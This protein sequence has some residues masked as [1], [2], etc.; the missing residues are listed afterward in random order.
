MNAILFDPS[1][2]DDAR[3]EQLYKGQLFVYSPSPS[4]RELCAF[5]REMIEDAFGSLDP[6]DAQHSLP[7]QDYVAILT[8]LKPAFIHHPRSKQLLQ[9]ILEELGCDLSKTYFDVPRMRSATHGGYLTSGIAYAFHPHR[10]TWYSAPPS[11]INWWLPIY[12]IEPNNAL[13]FHPRYWNEPV[14]NGSG[15]YNYDE[16]TRTGRQTAAQQIKTDIR[17]QPKPEEPIELDPQIRLITGA[18][19][20]L[21]FSGSQLHSTVP[22]TSGHTRFSID[23]RTV[24]I[25]DVRGKKGAPNIDSACTGTTLRDY[26]RGTDLQHIPE[27]VVLEY[28]TPPQRTT[29]LASHL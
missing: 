9:G 23:F 6:R 12:E 17:K 7:V 19:G 15:D 29:E 22:N 2:S 3:R 10:D 13:A 18:G 11:Q 27:D 8:K 25:E 5:G 26:L 28:D 14:R 1:L 20:I 4:S 21:L 24:H 16:W